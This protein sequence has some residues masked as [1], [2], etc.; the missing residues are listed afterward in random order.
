MANTTR[1]PIAVVGVSAL[2]PGSLNAEGFWRDILAGN[3]LIGPVPATHWLTE[4]YYDADPKAPD[5]TY[6]NRGGFL[7]DIDFDALGWGVP[8]SIIPATDTSQLLALIMAEQVLFDAWQEQFQDMDKSRMSC[9]LGVTSA[10]ELLATMVSRLQRPVWVKSLREAGIP[11]SEVQDACDRIADHYQPWQES[12]FPGLLGNVVAGRI[13]NR[14]DLGGTNCVT[15]AACASTFS[16]ISMGVQELYLGDSDVVITGGCDTL[17]DIFMYM[18]FSKTPALSASGDCRP[19]SDQADGTMLG[20]G[21]GMVALKRLEDAERD[22]DRIYA[23]ISGVGSSSDGRSKSVYAPVSEGQAKSIRRAYNHA[24]FDPGTI[25]L[26][27]AHGTGTRAGDA[28]EFNGL[29]LA[30]QESDREDHQW[31]SIGSVKSQ[32][33]HTKSAAGAAGIFKAVMALH[34]KVKPPTIKVDQLNPLLEIESSPFHVNTVARPWVRGSAHPR[35]AGVSSF[36]FGG[37]NFHIALEEYTGD[38]RAFRKRSLPGE[39]VVV[40]GDDAA[41]LIAN[42]NSLKERAS[43]EG[44]LQRLAWETQTNYTPLNNRLALYATTEDEL[45]T[46]LDR[47]IGMIQKAGDKP[48]EMPDGTVYGVGKAQGDVAFVFPGQGSQYIGMGGQ[49]AMS[50]D[51]AIGP[52]DRAADLKLDELRTLDQVV[53]PMPTFND[54]DK[55]EDEARLTSTQWAQPA[56]GCTSLSLLQMVRGLGLEAKAVAGHSYGEVTALHAAGVLSEEDMLKV[57]R[58][59]GEL[60]AEAAELPGAMTAVSATLDVVAP[61]LESLGTDD[62]VVAN[63]NA[64]D[65][66]VISGTV[67]A[68]RAAEAKF[69]TQGINFKP[70]SVATAFHSKV[71]SASAEPFSAFL[72][73][74]DFGDANIPVWSNESA[75]PYEDKAADKQARLG[76]QIANSVKWVDT[77]NG[78]YDAGIR[79]FIEVGPGSVLTK[80]VGRILEGKEHT[81]VTLDRRSKPGIESFFRGLAQL[82]AA[83]L[84]LEFASLWAEYGEPRDLDA[85]P[86]PKLAVK[87]NGSNYGKVYPPK[88]GAAALPGPNPE[89]QPETK[90]VEVPVEVIK[91]VPVEVPVPVA[92][93]PATAGASGL[94]ASGSGVAQSAEWLAVWQEAQRQLAVTQ[95]TFQQAIAQSQTSFLNAVQSSLNALGG[96]TV[97][98]AVSNQLPAFSGQQS[99]FSSGAALQAPAQQLVAAPQTQA[100]VSGAGGFK[101]PSSAAEVPAA[102]VAKPAPAPV[103]AAPAGGFDLESIMLG[104]VSGKTGY[105]REM[106][107]LSMDLEGD[108]GIDSIKRVEILS[109]VQDQA[110]GLP[111]VD[112]AELSAM[113]TLGEIVTFLSQFEVGGAAAAPA[114]AAPAVSGQQPAVSSAPSVDVEALMLAV[115]AEKTGYP[116]EMLENGMDLEGDLGIDSIKRVEILSAVQEQAPGLPEVDANAMGAM[117]TLGEIVDYLQSMLPKGGAPA[118]QPT[119]QPI[120][121]TQQ[122]AVDV[123][124]LMLEVV[125]E[126][127]GYPAEMLENGMDLE[128]DLGIDSIKRVEILSAVQ[129]QAPGLPEVDANAMGAMKTLGEIVDYLQSMLPAGGAPAPASSSQPSASSS[130]AA[131]SVDVHGI[132]LA[133]VAEKT[134]YPA[135][136]LENEMDL[137]GDLGIDS[138][139]RVEILSAVQEQAPGLPEVDANAMGAMKTLGEIVAYLESML[140]SGG[141]PAAA[142]SVQPS[143][144]SSPA[145]PS[146]D[147]HGIMLEVVAEKTG[148]PADMLENDMDLEGD[149]GIDSIKRVEILSAVQEQAPG[150]PEVDANAMGAMKTLGE[151]VGYLESMLPG[152]QAPAAQTNQEPRTKNQEPVA[153]AAQ[154]KNQEPTTNNQE[155]AVVT[156]DLGRFS[157]ELVNTPAAGL[158]QPGLWDAKEVLIVGGPAKLGDALAN[159]LKFRGLSARVAVAV[160]SK[161]D[162][163][164]YLGGLADVKNVDEAIAINSEAFGIASKIAAKFTADGGLFVTVQDTGGAFG[165]TE[166]D[167]TRAYLSGLSGLTKSANLEWTNASLK[168]I[169]IETGD[170]DAATVAIAL[171]N[172]LLQGGGEIEVGLTAD[173]QRLV[174]HSIAKE[175]TTGD[176]LLGSDDVIV[177]SGGARGVTAACVIEL[178]GTSKSKFILLGRTPLAEEPAGL[179]N[180]TTDADLKG[181]LLK[182]AQAAGEKVTPKDLQRQAKK[183]LAGREIRETIAAVKAAGGDAQYVSVSVTDAEGMSAALEGVRTQWGPI[184]GFVHGAGVLADK[185]IA[186]MTQDDF[187]FVFNTKIDGLRA[188]LTA[189]ANDPL[190]F[191]CNFSSVA[192]RTGNNGQ[193]NYAM[194]NEVLNKTA[195]A[196]GRERNILVKSL[197]W[198]P[199]EGGMVSP[200]LKRH[201]AA[202]GVPMIPLKTGAKMFVDEIN[203]T[204]GDVELV[205]GGEPQAAALMGGTEAK[206]TLEV[207][208]NSK[209]HG[210]LEGHTI[211]DGIVVPVVLV[212]EWFSRLARAYAPQLKLAAVK[213]LKVLKGI[214]LNDFN[215]K[216]DRFLLT[217]QPIQ[218]GSELSLALELKGADGTFYYKAKAEMAPARGTQRHV[219]VSPSL[220]QWD[221]RVVYGDVLFHTNDFQVIKQLDGVGADGISGDLKG[222]KEASWSWEPWATDVAAF[223]GGLQMLLL[224]ARE[225]L[226]GA[227]LPMAIGEFWVGSDLPNDGEVRCVAQCQPAGKSGATADVIFETTDG[228]RIAEMKKVELIL[229]P[230]VKRS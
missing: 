48:F 54:A 159:E 116:A 49:V 141:A 125:A 89:R 181:A 10:Q 4:D 71:V 90:I 57:A 3:D 198:G 15:D 225:N 95:S 129:E 5:K 169:D 220:G 75:Q 7:K 217:A 185:F 94:G 218:N 189:T 172:E 77:I 213:D 201:F 20:E 45:K 84:P 79:H 206:L 226:G 128:G 113:K 86:K 203:S 224:W 126:K 122:P 34:A 164:I 105:P 109:A 63:H 221:D 2:F 8:P 40:T 173:G 28:A 85:L 133:V 14:L 192:A 42:A 177:V 138:I 17:N 136:M 74:V 186:D 106:L 33:G 107:D 12:S 150:L 32:I 132:M 24:G 52:W 102:P 230:D 55:A 148:Y 144:S 205:L 121:N 93:A 76:R 219:E 216:G 73:D 83:G 191:I 117:K 101:L 222:V 135:D 119:Q 180:A 151:I 155:P 36:G 142:T 67:E 103:A 96:Q 92:A 162:A 160:S 145:A 43:M 26:I 64:P 178:A 130:P 104:V 39:L 168:A 171:A 35:R 100:P 207:N 163:V 41:G 23:V 25:E 69:E 158:A 62:V 195:W 68:V 210:Y 16:A 215:G 61:V 44:M 29:K 161:S 50:F 194:A 199:W 187:D 154:T 143:A 98:P 19:F 147:V 188:L 65:Q 81:A 176:A 123:E 37:S 47:A 108:L 193:A 127:T 214:K 124:A 223:D 200:E 1:P 87:I 58:K 22:G 56:I 53:F 157:L 78:M 66:V 204:D 202:L 112:T 27:E 184:T 170:R 110:P 228:H 38:N 229:R 18:C 31:C 88:G 174:P 91:E 114:P 115:V 9:I 208:V 134:G 227:A 97:T 6:A 137:E 166:F 156:A 211:G 190:K 209:S 212:L 152:A 72:K 80:L 139:K 175:V 13:A 165:T 11:E 30:F 140:P 46:K 99:A 196:I 118:A 51:A 60:M 111:D 167:S 149:L 131:P 197:G 21:L 182:L 120:A 70:L 183:I 82:V 153:P 59:R 146:V 179:E